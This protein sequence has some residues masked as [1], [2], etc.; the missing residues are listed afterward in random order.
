[1]MFQS[2]G[3]PPA[4]VDDGVRDVG[5]GACRTIEDVPGIESWQFVLTSAQPA[6][7]APT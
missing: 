4:T 5:G 2:L 7:L 1:M 3:A 6:N